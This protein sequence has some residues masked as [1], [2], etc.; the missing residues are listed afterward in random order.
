M[1]KLQ[2]LTALNYRV[3]YVEGGV[4]PSNSPQLL[5]M[6]KFS[7]D[8]SQTIGEETRITGPDPT[9]FNRD[10]EV[11][12]VPG[13]EE[14]ATLSVG[15]RSTSQASILIG[16]KN[17]R[18][19]VDLF[20]LAGRCGNPQDFSNGGE[21]MIYFPDGKVGAHNYENIGAWGQDE[22]NPAN[23]MV[24]M[25]AEEYYEYLY[26]KQEQ[27]GSVYT[28]RQIYTVD[29]YTGNSCENCPDPCDRVLA[30]M[31]GASATPGTQP[32]LLYSS[33]GGETFSS[34]VISTL[35]SNEEVVDGAVIG[36]DIVYLSNTSNSIHWTNIELLYDGTNSW[37][38]VTSGFVAS[39]GPR[40][41]SSAD[42]RHTWIV[43]DGGYI[44]FCKNPRVGVEVQDAGV[45][46][47]QHLQA[48]SAF[49]SEN[50]L[51][52]G[53]SNAVLFTV[54]AGVSWQ[55]VTGPAVGV[56]LGACW[57]W[58]E[59]IWFVG[60]GAGGTG[61]L[62]LTLNSGKTWTQVGLPNSYS[63]IYKIVFVTEGE[64]YLLATDGSQTYVL[65]TVT[66]G[67]EWS[68]LPQ[69]KSGTPVDNTFLTDLAICSKYA[70]TAF[71]AGL[72]PNGTAGM[73]LKMAGA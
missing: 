3:W 35:F 16:W 70:N 33:N 40:A 14:R 27:I 47:T 60:E 73:L 46:T 36:G 29:V 55:T 30:T 50:V 51:A 13:S 1:S 9:D 48:V 39:K 64:G 56:N 23:E 7:T 19:R 42:A 15:I 58:D 17:K 62:W 37:S 5:A 21:K 28:T 38:E 52:V 59:D 57:M 65:R 24:D 61:K 67:N 4:H 72:A 22:N 25:T 18:C 45:A 44:Y 20:A 54:N 10:I 49:D 6:G 2:A 43:G 11:G 26:M 69:G 63:R 34:Q 71:A 53:N 12:T 8:P 66:A 41:M 68:V 32:T 31:A